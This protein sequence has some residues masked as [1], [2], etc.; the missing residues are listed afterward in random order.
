MRV[1]LVASTQE[2]VQG[3]QRSRDL[4]GLAGFDH[5]LR[6][7]ATRRRRAA[8]QL[9]LPTGQFSLHFVLLAKKT[10]SCALPTLVGVPL[11]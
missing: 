7:A 4:P 11:F 6:T 3:V 5:E 1:M 9:T 2:Q 10:K 8:T